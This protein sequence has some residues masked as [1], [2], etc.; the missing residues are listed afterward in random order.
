MLGLGLGLAFAMLRFFL[1][2][3]L[4]L[5]LLLALP[6]GF[7][8]FFPLYSVALGAVREREGVV[9]G[10]SSTTTVENDKLL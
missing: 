7:F 6:N 1:L 5:L 2:L 8:A 3:L 4:L 10:G 9:E